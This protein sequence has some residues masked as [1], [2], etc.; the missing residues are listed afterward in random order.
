MLFISFRAA[1]SDPQV[2]ERTLNVVRRFVFIGDA[3]VKRAKILIVGPF[4]PTVGGITSCIEKIVNSQ[5]KNFY[6][7]VTFTTS[8]PTV[9]V[10]RDVSDYSILL[11]MDPVHLI[12]AAIVTFYHLIKFPVTLSLEAPKLVHIH[13]TDYLPFWE[14]SIYTIVTKLFSKGTIIH[15][16]ATSF[17]DFYKNG[18][19]IMRSIIRKILKVADE[20][21]VLSPNSC[22]FFRR[23]VPSCKLSVISNAA[24]IPDLSLGEKSSGKANPEGVRV[25]FVGG[26]E[27]KRKG[28]FDVLKA[29]PLVTERYGSNIHF[30]FVGKYDEEKRRIINEAEMH[31]HCLEYMGF[32]EKDEMH[33]VRQTSDIYVL[34][35]YAEGLPIAL[36]EAMA[37]GLPVVSTRVGSISE[38][39]EEGVNGFLIEPGDHEA[40]AQRI[41]LLA[42]NQKLRQLM[43]KANIEKIRKFY[44]LENA[45]KNLNEIYSRVI[46]EHAG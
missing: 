12:G 26:E 34:P 6:E 2:A 1:S 8:R 37:A 40:L 15:V 4:P 19:L 22:V 29:I 11:K 38:V 35:S 3:A 24:E 42:K 9:G 17:E 14:N 28:F 27:A 36:L 7:F 25:L 13:T 45:M 23:I 33:E 21:I 31:F 20:V 18:N 46:L 44:S 43:S 16:H 32:L 39:V 10:R 5:L 30:L 41:V